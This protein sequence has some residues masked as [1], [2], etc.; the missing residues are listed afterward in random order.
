LNSNTKG[1]LVA[2][3]L[4]AAALAVPMGIA[5]A[6]NIRA[7]KVV[8]DCDGCKI[9]ISNPGPQGPPG[10]AGADSTVPGPPGPPGER[11]PPGNNATITAINGTSIVNGT[12]TGG[13]GNGT[14]GNGTSGNLTG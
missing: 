1:V 6:D 5:S 11:G 3:L 7:D 14:T 4:V 2:T 13:S 12:G 9:T 8:I 10:P